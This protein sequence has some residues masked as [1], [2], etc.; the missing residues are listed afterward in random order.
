MAP[1]PRQPMEWLA[2]LYAG[3]VDKRDKL[4]P[5]YRREDE[6]KYRAMYVTRPGHLTYIR[7]YLEGYGR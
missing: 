5:L 3:M 6:A 1:P 4:R 2:G 7:A